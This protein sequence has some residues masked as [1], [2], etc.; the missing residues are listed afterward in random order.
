MLDHASR[1]LGVDEFAF[2]KGCTYGTVLVDVEAG[3]VV[4][5]LPDRTSETLAAWLCGSE[6]SRHRP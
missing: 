5:V 1:V 3:R 2:R 4:D 6:V